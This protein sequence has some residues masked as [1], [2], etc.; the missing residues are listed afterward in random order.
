MKIVV[1]LRAQLLFSLDKEV[2]REG[3]GVNKQMIL[4]ATQQH[5]GCVHLILWHVRRDTRDGELHEFDGV[6]H[7]N[8]EGPT[9]R[10]VA[11]QKKTAIHKTV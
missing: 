2:E 5:K 1:Q 11:R 10:E 8:R 9:L 3:E 4:A 7:A 6:P